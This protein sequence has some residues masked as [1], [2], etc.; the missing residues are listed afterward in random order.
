MVGIT[1]SP[2]TLGNSYQHI[3]ADGSDLRF[4]AAD[5]TTPLNYWIESWNPAGQSK[6]WV[7]VPTAGTA[8]IKMKYGN[9]TATSA[10]AGAGVFNFFDDFN[11][12]IWTKNTSNPVMTRT[13][14]WEA[15]AICEPSVLYENNTFKM[16]YMGCAT[17]GGQ[18]AALG[19]ATSPDGL[20]WTKAAGNPILQRPQP[21]D[22]SHHRGEEPG[23]LLPVCQRLPLGLRGPGN[24]YRWTSTDGLNW[25]NKTIVL[26]PTQSW[27]SHIENVGITIDATHLA[28]A[29]PVRGSKEA[30]HGTASSPDNGLTWTK[31]STTPVIG[32]IGLLRRRSVSDQGRQHLLHLAFAGVQRPPADLLRQEH[33]HGQLADGRHWAADELYPAVGAGHRP[34]GGVVEPHLTDAELVE[35]RRQS[36]DVLPGR[37]VSAG[38]GHVQRDDGPTGQ[39][40][41]NNRRPLKQWA[42]SHYGMVENNQL[43]ISDNGTGDPSR[44]TR[45]WPNSAT[46]RAIPSNAGHRPTPATTSSPPRR[47]PRAG[48]ARRRASP[49]DHP[50]LSVVMRYRDDPT[51]P[52]FG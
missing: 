18:D 4:T 44:C 27:E 9:P 43:K 2:Q 19:Y 14:P 35:A 52:A 7:K 31:L 29:L 33:R 13:A 11:N 12:G 32:R 10:S 34:V 21:G 15:D 50:Q 37:A 1:L 8:A 39:Q 5:G 41:N 20:N 24:L 48:R 3:N 45:T 51:W 16:W 25:S 26:Q 46:R 23:H 36:L 22:H 17:V 38:R 42:A 28:H 47:A 30:S 49:Y 40:L 6:V